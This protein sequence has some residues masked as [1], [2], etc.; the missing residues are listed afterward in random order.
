MKKNAI[1]TVFVVFT[2]VVVLCSWLFSGAKR[3]WDG[4]VH[5]PLKRAQ[6]FSWSAPDDFF[7][8]KEAGGRPS[9]GFVVIPDGGYRAHFA[10]TENISQWRGIFLSEHP[11]EF[12]I[13]H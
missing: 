11:L 1:F 2:G 12:T 3:G 7:T 6:E 9:P 8:G 5:A 4:Y 13:A 10:L